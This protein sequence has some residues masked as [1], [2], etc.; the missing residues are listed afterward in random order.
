MAK[1]TD[2]CAYALREAD[3]LGADE[4]EAY[5]VTKETLTIRLANS[6]ILESKGMLETGIGVRTVK[7]KAIG[8]SCTNMTD[9]EEIKGTVSRAISLGAIAGP[10]MHW[11]GFPSKEKPPALPGLYDKKTEDCSLE[12]AVEA[13]ARMLSAA[14]DY[15]KTSVEVSGSLNVIKQTAQIENSNGVKLSTK[16]TIVVG[17]TTSEISEGEAVAGGIGFHATRALSGFEAEKVGIQSTRMAFESMNAKKVEPGDYTFIMEPYAAG[18]IFGFVF[19]RNMISKAYQEG[20]SCYSE[21]LG[22]QVADPTL[23]IYDDPHY[24]EAIG[25][26]VF[27]EEGVPTRRTSLIEK[28]VFSKVLYDTYHASRDGKESTGSA[29]RGRGPYGRSHEL[30]APSSHNISVQ[31]GSWTKEELIRETK[32]GLLVGRLWYTWP[33]NPVK[34]DFSTATKAGVY[35]VENGEVKHPVRMVRLYNNLVRVLSKIDVADDAKHVCQWF[36]P[37]VITPT[38]RFDGGRATPI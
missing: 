38:I 27:D 7:G 18:D 24:P 25:S 4:A 10:T 34:G 28:G 20:V 31:K 36:S 37:P 2:L 35:L 23:T 29:L 8:F 13:A 19:E 9:R 26:K 5:L 15:R 22:Q 11:T 14:L 12:D 17:S 6:Q 3:K 33:V 16:E 21:K 30:P 1:A 32:R